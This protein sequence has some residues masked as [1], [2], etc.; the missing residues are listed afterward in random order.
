MN[1]LKM[2]SCRM[3]YIPSLVKIGTGV[4]VKVLA[5]QFERL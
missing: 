2:D 3:I 5:Q 1:A 4:H